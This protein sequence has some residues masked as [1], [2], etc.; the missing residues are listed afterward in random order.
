DPKQMLQRA[1]VN[2]LDIERIATID[3]GEKKA[4]ALC[5]LQQAV[6]EQRR[7]RAR[8]CADDFGDC[9]FT[10][11]PIGRSTK[12]GNTDLSASN[13]GRML[14]AFRQKIAEIDNLPSR[15]HSQRWHNRRICSSEHNNEGTRLSSLC[16]QR[17]FTPL[18]LGFPEAAGLEAR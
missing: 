11:T 4:I 9:T 14:K 8:I 15:C 13:S 3:E 17:S 16:A 7:A 5:D 6:N 10:E 2:R 1:G 18:L 12:K